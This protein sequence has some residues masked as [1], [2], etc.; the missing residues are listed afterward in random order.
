M[1]R[2]IE[3]QGGTYAAANTALRAT[4]DDTSCRIPTD[5]S[6]AISTS[7]HD[8]LRSATPIATSAPIACFE[9]DCVSYVLRAY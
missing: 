1:H 7:C 5:M 6:H 2:G 3:V 8:K 9:C 4:Y